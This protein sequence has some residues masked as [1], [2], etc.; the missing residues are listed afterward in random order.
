MRRSLIAT[1]ATALWL[2]SASAHELEVGPFRITH[3]WTPASPAGATAAPLYMSITLTGESADR[4]IGASSPVADR[5][6]F[7]RHTRAGEAVTTDV[8]PWLV[9]TANSA[10]VLKP[11]GLCLVLIGLHA[12]LQEFDSFPLTLRFEKADS[13]TVEVTVEEPG[14]AEPRED[15]G[16]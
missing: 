1:M 16:L 5:V 11:D 6:E 14:A 10:A 7:H 15:Y 4:L 12:P 13:I 8:L 9:L 3:P 2:G